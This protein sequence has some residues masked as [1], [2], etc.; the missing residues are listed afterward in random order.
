MSDVDI[1]VMRTLLDEHQRTSE[2]LA[3]A[4]DRLSSRVDELDRWRWRTMGAGTLLGS[5]VT[6]VGAVVVT[7]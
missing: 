7:R 6:A 2:R 1:A 4:I 5:V 3:S